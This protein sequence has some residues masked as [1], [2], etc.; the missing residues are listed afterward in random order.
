MRIDTHTPQVRHQTFNGNWFFKFDEAL[1]KLLKP[2]EVVTIENQNNITKTIDVAKKLYNPANQAPVNLKVKNG[3][4]EL[5]FIYNNSSWHKVRLSKKGQEIKE[6]EILHP[7]NEKEFAFYS[8]GTYS[9]RII[10]EKHIKNFNEILADWLPR[11]LKK[12]TKAQRT[13]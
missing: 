11:L 5:E 10:D 8:T 7:K 13:Q 3:N 6:F 12:H 1:G 4:K 9:C 2:K